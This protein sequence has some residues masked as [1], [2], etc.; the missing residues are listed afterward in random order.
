MLYLIS[1][2]HGELSDFK[3]LLKK[4]RFDRK[5]D[6]LIIMGDIFDRGSDGIAVLEFIA[7]F[8]L[9][10]SMELLIGNHELFAMMYMEGRL[11]GRIW[12]IFGGDDTL[13]D[14][15]KMDADKQKKL[16]EFLKSLPYYTEISSSFLGDIVVTHTGIDCDNYVMNDD[17]TINLKKSIEKAVQNNLYNF[18]TGLDLHRIPAADKKKFDKYLIVGHVPCYRLNEDMSY[19]FYRTDYYM[20]IDAGAGHKDRGGRLGC[21][22][23]TT[24]EE[25]YI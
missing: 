1:D 9:D 13:Q 19:K 24:D 25:I 21:Y 14:I 17:G 6:R 4:I 3:R 8:L 22:C 23:V 18:I 20:C 16:L 2:I 12:S 10:N 7:P 15:K 11:D 5:K